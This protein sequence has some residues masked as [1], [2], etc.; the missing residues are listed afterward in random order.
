VKEKGTG[1]LLSFEPTGKPVG[2][3]AP[4]PA[5]SINGNPQPGNHKGLPTSKQQHRFR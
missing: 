2:G 1:E 4:V 5:L 3:Q